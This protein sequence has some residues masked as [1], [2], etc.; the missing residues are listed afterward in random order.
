MLLAVDT[1]TQWIGLALFNGFEVNAEMIWQTHGFHT[2]ELA[3]AVHGLLKRSNVQPADLQVLA[4]A[5][6]PGSFTS[7]RIGLALVKGMSLALHLPVVGIPSLDTLAAAQP[8][9][10][11]PLAAVLRAGRQRLA[12]GWYSVVNGA[13]KAQGEAR[14]FTFEDFAGTFHTP[15]FVCGELT[16][17]ERQALAR[18]RKNVVL[19]SPAASLR[20]PAYLA[21]LAW[22][23]WQAGQSDEVVSLSPICLHIAEV[24]PG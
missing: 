1:S 4:V 22:R 21:E 14:V 8:I 23:R 13:W 2:V 5:T 16:A 7:L 10:T 19:A 6:G 20:R 12:V 11:I 18:K 3:P 9:A 17:E 24:V 15:T